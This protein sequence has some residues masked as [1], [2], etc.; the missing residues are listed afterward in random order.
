LAFALNL[1]NLEV[2]FYTLTLS[3][4]DDAAFAA[5]GFGSDVRGR[6]EQI[7]EHEIVHV[8]LLQS[9]LG[10]SAPLPCNYTL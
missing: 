5:A 9:V 6:F 2:D 7:L 4:F 10:S 8:S 3:M 1:E